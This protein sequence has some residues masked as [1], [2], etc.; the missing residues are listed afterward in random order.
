MKIHVNTE[1]TTCENFIG[2]GTEWDSRNYSD[3][4][5]ER[6]MFGKL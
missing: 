2:F 3:S 1:T 5:K 6:I 4:R